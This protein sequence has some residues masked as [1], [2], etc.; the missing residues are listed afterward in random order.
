[1]IRAARA[2][3]SPRGASCAPPGSWPTTSR[4]STTSTSRPRRSPRKRASRSRGRGCRTPTP[5]TSTCSP[6]SCA[7]TSRRGAGAVS[8]PGAR[9][10][11]VVGG[12]VAG[13]TAAY[14][15]LQRDA[16]VDVAVLEARSAPSAASCRTR[17]RSATSRCAAGA[18]SFLARKPWAV[19]PVQGARH[20]ARDAG[21]DRAP[22][23][24]P[25][26]A[27]CRCSR[28]RRSA[29]PATSATCCAGRGCRG[30]APPGG[31]GPG[32]SRSAAGRRR[33]VARV[34]AAPPARR[35]GDR[36]RGGA[37]ARRAVR[38]RRRSAQR[39]GDVPRAG[40][41]GA[42]PGQPDPRLAGGASKLAAPIA[43]GP[44]FLRPRG[45]RRP[46]AR[47][48]RRRA[49]RTGVRTGVAAPPSSRPRPRDARERRD[50]RGRSPSCSPRPAH[51][52]AGCSP[53]PRPIGRAPTS[54][55][56]PYASTGVVLLVYAARTRRP[57]FPTARASS[58]RAAWRR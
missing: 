3:R 21:R 51:E 48:A 55:A 24:G 27:S 2:R 19:G 29:S 17:D 52:A 33:R 32:A 16:A 40:R 49:R 4:S 56:I 39:A 11:A 34:A 18:D 14:R 41:V 57:G 58:C 7:T 53:M 50:R 44:M 13:L 28:T 25:T 5:S 8:G 36:P 1:M 15:L 54:R 6:R 26:P 42:R 31:A 23:C 47:R 38:R 10:V 12:G 46:A 9:R 30:R 22:S 20:R 37:A 35:R 43:A 45:G